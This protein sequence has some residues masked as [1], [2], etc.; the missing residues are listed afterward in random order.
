M[1][2]LHTNIK[3][4]VDTLLLSTDAQNFNNDTLKYS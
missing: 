1:L 4:S 3:K 2:P